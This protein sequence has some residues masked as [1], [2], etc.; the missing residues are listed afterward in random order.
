MSQLS[1]IPSKIDPEAQYIANILIYNGLY[2][3]T[4][5]FPSGFNAKRIGWVTNVDKRLDDIYQLLYQH[6]LNVSYH[7]QGID[8]IISL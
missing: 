2:I 4:K 6:G 7:S 3:Y 8:I 1:K 5:A